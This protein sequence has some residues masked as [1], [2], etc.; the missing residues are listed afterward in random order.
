MSLSNDEKAIALPFSLDTFGNI[1][2]TIDQSII[3]ADRVKSAIG[4]TLGERVM[5]P[6]YGTKISQAAFETRTSAE[7]LM[8]SEIERVF[9]MDLPLL[10]LEGV[11]YSY[12]DVENLIVADVTY[13]LPNNQTDNTAV[14]IITVS[15]NNPPYEETL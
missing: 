8:S 5:R 3:W 1:K 4:T 6:G 12:N 14:G 7:T 11:T 9:H 15:Q 13:T 2:F 10:R